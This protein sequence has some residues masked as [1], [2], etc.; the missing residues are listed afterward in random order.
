MPGPWPWARAG[1]WRRWARPWPGGARGET[2]GAGPG[3]WGPAASATWLWSGAAAASVLPW[4]MA[5]HL[6]RQYAVK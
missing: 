4:P 5:R 1:R 3:Q 6:A 2:S